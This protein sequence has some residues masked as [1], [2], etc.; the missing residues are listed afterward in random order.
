MTKR[1][2]EL[3][4][5]RNYEQALRDAEEKRPQGQGYT[6]F[7]ENG[8]QAGRI[9][10]TAEDDTLIIE[11]S[12]TVTAKLRGEYLNSICQSLKD[13]LSEAEE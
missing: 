5:Q 3:N 2:K 11:I 4:L 10:Y 7:S 1:G 12:G 8:S 9:V 13:L 6:I